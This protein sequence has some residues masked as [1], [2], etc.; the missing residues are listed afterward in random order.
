MTSSLSLWMAAFT[1]T[2]I[3]NSCKSETGTKSVN[4]KST[5]PASITEQF[6]YRFLSPLPNQTFTIGEKINVSL[7]KTDSSSVDSLILI[8]ENESFPVNPATDMKISITP[9]GVKVG[10][11]RLKLNIYH[12]GGKVPQI[13]SVPVSFLSDIKPKEYTYRVVNEFPHDREFYTQGFEYQKGY[14]FEGTGQR[15]ES[16]LRKIVY[17]TGEI[18][19]SR[20]LSPDLFG[21]GITLLNG[22]IYQITYSTQVG[23]IYDIE[24]FEQLQKIYYQ[25]RE[26]WGLTNNGKEIIMSD[27]TNILYF[28]DPEY[29]SVLHQIEVYDNVQAVDSLNE[30]EYLNGYIYANRYQT[31]QVV[32]IDPLNGKVVGRADMKGLLKPEDRQSGTDV[33]NGIA[34]DNEN[35]RLFVTGKYWPKVFQVELIPK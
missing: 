9:K 6:S 35:K 25:N 13:V 12:Q 26:G 24:T 10:A 33:L 2:I 16:A 23:F 28:R 27:G 7:Q 11:V 5:V 17:N 30:L 32:I 21:E 3:I 22:K 4:N 8:V 19:K 15:G 1:M 31:E 18:I 29:F 14:F 20:T 34:W